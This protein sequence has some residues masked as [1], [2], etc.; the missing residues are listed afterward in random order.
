MFLAILLDLKLIF[1]S[2]DEYQHIIKVT[3]KLLAPL[4]LNIILTIFLVA[5]ISVT[6]QEWNYLIG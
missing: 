1:S 2:S 3:E 6:L 5:K 4:G